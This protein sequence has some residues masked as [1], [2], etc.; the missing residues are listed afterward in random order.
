MLEVFATGGVYTWL[1]LEHVE[2]ITMNPPQAPRDVI[3]RPA[4]ITLTDGVTGDVLLPG[5]YPGSHEHADEEIRLGRG[6]EWLGSG[7]EVTRGAGGRLFLTGETTI[8][9]TKVNEIIRPTA[10][11]SETENESKSES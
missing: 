8:E 1:P 4:N 11:A 9:F 5:L 10:G 7:G 2:S 3:L 6:T